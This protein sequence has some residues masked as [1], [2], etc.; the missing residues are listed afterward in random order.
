MCSCKFIFIFL[1]QEN[2]ENPSDLCKMFPNLLFSVLCISENTDSEIEDKIDESRPET[3]NE[4]LIANG[5]YG[6]VESVVEIKRRHGRL[7]LQHVHVIQFPKEDDDD[8]TT[9]AERLRYL[10]HE[11]CLQC[12][13]LIIENSSEM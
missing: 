11:N 1:G 13:Y 10:S 12:F 7:G 2:K 6:E 8:T 5:R 3:F 4:L 9:K